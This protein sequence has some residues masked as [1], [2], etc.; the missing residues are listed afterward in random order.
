M[1]E[2]IVAGAGTAGLVAA[3]ALAKAGF[4]TCLIG[5]V[6]ARA[7]A[8]TVAL[9]DGSVRLLKNLG[10][11]DAVAPD[12]APLAIMRL[13]DDTGSLF[14]APPVDF[15]AAEIGLD[16]F[17]HNIETRL[18]VARLAGIAGKTPGL[19]LVDQ[20]VAKIVFGS[21]EVT[22]TCEDGVAF[23]DNCWSQPTGAIRWPAAPRISQPAHGPIRK[24]RS[25][26]YWRMRVRIT[27][28]PPNS[29][30]APGPALLCRYPPPLPNRTAPAW[31]G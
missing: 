11:W 1:S 24:W 28:S 10:L 4:A 12:T 19:T 17:G 13:V 8:R 27:P 25:P 20:R 15:C 3:I 29:T 30:P 9:L 21:Q 23:L 18:L 7:S 5:P 22:L 16:V 6:D 26:P 2:I 14:A 31:F